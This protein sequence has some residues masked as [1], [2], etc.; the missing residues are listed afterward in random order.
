MSEVNKFLEECIS[1]CYRG[2]FTITVFMKLLK[3]YMNNEKIE[4]KWT[5]IIHDENYHWFPVYCVL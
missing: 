1:E 2:E 3:E 5:A 4:E